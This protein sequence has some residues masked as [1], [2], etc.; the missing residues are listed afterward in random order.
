MKL[1]KNF[2]LFKDCTALID[3]NNKI[4]I[5]YKDI[6]NNSK[7]L[8]KK[9]KN[10]KLI[11]IIAENTLGS[12]LSYIYAVIN[13]YIIIFVDSNLKK[14]E[15]NK[16]IN[17]YK[18]NFI[19]TNEK[20]LSILNRKYSKIFNTFKNVY[21]F[22]TNYKICKCHKKLSLLLPTS[23]TIGNNKYV[24]LS[25]NNIYQNT[26]SII[27]YLKI[28]KKDVAITN[29][30]YFYSYMLSVLNTHLQKGAKIVITNKTI[31]QKEFWKIFYDKKI[32]SFN[33]VPYAYEIIDRI[34]YNKI[35]TKNLRYITQ[36]GG[37][38]DKSILL[39]IS[40]LA[41]K[42]NKQFFSMYGQTEASPRISYLNPKFA[43][44]KAGSIG[45]AIPNTK[46]WIEI[47][48]KKIKKPYTKGNIF[49]SGKNIMLGYAK[50][51]QDLSKIS[52]INSLDT[53]DIGFFDIEG[54]YFITGRSSRYIKLYGNRI[55]LD[56]IELKMKQQKLNMVCISKFDTLTIFYT[57][58]KK[59]KKI[60]EQLFL[61]L[62]QNL[63]KIKFKL[64]K[65]FP[66]T[67]SNKISY[68]SLYNLNDKI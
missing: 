45:K 32:S 59:L 66:R 35:F 37:K 50:N 60:K 56:E 13:N 54:F 21:F 58:N 7:A 33:G 14:N 19:V 30:P 42:K 26:I 39:K 24:K 17:N 62:N 46:M 4:K 3:D 64:I 65:K 40:K 5:S 25:S 47:K 31:I 11:L 9:V 20:K 52:K 8:S 49:F 67:N 61:I 36:A 44:K 12:I 16:T 53:G 43:I 2:K 29:M 55:D 38:L 22:K 34:G 23:G 1:F 57:D 10:K 28:S 41:E 18:P 51:Y 15:I 48:R 63:N 68:N 27:K 6:R